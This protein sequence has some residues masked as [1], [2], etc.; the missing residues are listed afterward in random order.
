MHNAIP[1]WTVYFY[2]ISPFAYGI[3]ALIINEF[4]S[5]RWQDLKSPVPGVSLGNA[6]LGQLDFY[7]DRCVDMST[8]IRTPSPQCKRKTSLLACPQHHIAGHALS[9]QPFSARASW[10]RYWIWVGIAF[11]IGFFFVLTQ[12]SALF[13]AVLNPPRSKPVVLTK[14]QMADNIEC[15]SRMARD[16]RLSHCC[17]LVAAYLHVSATVLQRESCIA[18]CIVAI[19]CTFDQ[20]LS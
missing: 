9:W 19:A 5:P 3:R 4:T 1:L 7:T 18:S 8:R 16:V 13:L 10:Y 20:R 11:N 15:V 14:E 12:L 17:A 2:W 6:S